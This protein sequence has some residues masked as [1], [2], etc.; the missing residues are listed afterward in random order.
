MAH[1]KTYKPKEE[2]IKKLNL[3]LKKLEDETEDIKT[4]KNKR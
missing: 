4:K 1:I 2:N 3:F